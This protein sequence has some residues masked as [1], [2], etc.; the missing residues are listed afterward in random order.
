MQKSSNVVNFNKTTCSPLGKTLGLSYLLSSLSN[1]R[2][3]IAKR[4]DCKM[5]KNGTLFVV[6]LL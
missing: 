2:G 6:L 5:S 4:P 1:G 3:A